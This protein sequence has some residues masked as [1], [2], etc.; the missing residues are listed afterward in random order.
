MNLV[1]VGLVENI[2]NV[3]A[4]NYKNTNKSTCAIY[5]HKNILFIRGLCGNNGH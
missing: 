1:H 3:V 5:T 4:L 2:K